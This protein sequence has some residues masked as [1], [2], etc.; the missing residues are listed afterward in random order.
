VPT[1]GYTNITVR[2]DVR[3]SNTAS[4]YLRFQYTIDGTNWVDGPQL[5]APGG[6]TWWSS[7][8]INNSK[9]DTRFFVDLSSTQE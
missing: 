3:W 6:D 5:V 7:Q 2:F 1:T 9:G 4:K 8:D